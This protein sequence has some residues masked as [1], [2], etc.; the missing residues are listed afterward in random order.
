[1]TY[2]YAELCK[3]IGDRRF[4]D[5]IHA[6]E[7]QAE[8]YRAEAGP[9]GDQCEYTQ[10]VLRMIAKECAELEQLAYDRYDDLRSDAL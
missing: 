9:Y 6:L 4:S 10:K 8:E 3:K 5:Q 7:C 1:M 2:R